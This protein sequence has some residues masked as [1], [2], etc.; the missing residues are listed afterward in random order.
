MEIEVKVKLKS[1]SRLRSLLKSAGATFKGRALEKN[2]LYDYPDRTLSRTD[3]L[4]RVREDRRV[5]LT[6]KGPRLESEYKE[7]EEIEFEFPD[8]S[9]AG[10]LLH[11][12]GFVK[13]FYYEK[14]RETWELD[15]CKITID[16]LPELGLFAEIEGPSREEIAATVK[17]LK[18]PRRYVA[19][20]YVEL[21]QEYS[22]KANISGCDFRF[23]P[24]HV[25]VLE[26]E[27]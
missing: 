13:W 15:R 25:S 7:R 5:R 2:W 10:S 1:P 4:L 21:L 22:Q 11:S 19:E 20:T 3:R 18:L 24:R 12:I 8:I 26:S 17:K 27:G 14:V 23:V 6:F 9:S 16:E